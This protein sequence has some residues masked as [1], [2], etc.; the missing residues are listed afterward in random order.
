[1]AWFRGLVHSNFRLSTGSYRKLAVVSLKHVRNYV[2]HFLLEKRILFDEESRCFKGGDSH[3]NN[4]IMPQHIRVFFHRIL[5]LD[6]K[7]TGAFLLESRERQ[8]SSGTKCMETICEATN[9]N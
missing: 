5:P 1:M 4:G 7:S 9:R 8:V 6:R 3:P 2:Y